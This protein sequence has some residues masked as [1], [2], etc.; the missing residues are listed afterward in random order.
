MLFTLGH[1]PYHCDLNMLLR[2]VSPGDDLLLLQ[3]GVIAALE[4]SAALELLL[5]APISVCA[6][7]DD[8]NARGLAAQISSRIRQVGY[9]EFVRLAVKHRGHVAW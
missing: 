6:L 7:Q 1:S 4:G 3:D 5:N 9:N 8:I 2:A